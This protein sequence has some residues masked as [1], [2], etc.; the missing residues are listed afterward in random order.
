[1]PR[2]A[3][4][5]T[6]AAVQAELDRRTTAYLAARELVVPYYRIGYTLAFPLPLDHRPESLPPSPLG[7]RPYPWLIWLGWHLEDRWRTF[8]TGRAGE[9][10]LARELVAL[11]EWTSYDA[12][13]GGAGLV[14][15]ALAGV[16]GAVLARADGHEPATVAAA[17]TVGRRLLEESFRPWYLD[18]WR[19]VVP[20]AARLEALHNIR[21]IAL[22]RAAQLASV[23]DSDATGELEERAGQVY[24]AWL[25]RR[26]AG[27]PMTEGPAYDGFLLDTLTEWIAARPDRDE[28]LKR[29]ED[30]L[31][32]LP[33]EWA[34]LS[35]PGRPDLLAPVGDTEGEMPYWLA[36]AIRLCH[37]YGD[38]QA[39]A[40][41]RRTSLS[42]VPAGALA[43]AARL[44]ADPSAPGREP[45][46][47]GV[48][49]GASA[50]TM[51]A[52]WEP[53]DPLVVVG[54]SRSPLGHLHHDG[55]HVLIGWHGRAWITDPGYQQYRPGPE[56][57]FTVGPEAHN[58][59]VIGGVSQ[60]ERDAVPSIL[61]EDAVGLDLSGCYPDLPGAEVRREVRLA[62]GRVVVR[63]EVRGLPAGT[64]VAT[65]W[66]AGAGL[67][68]S[69]DSGAARLSDGRRA[70][71]IVTAPGGL[72][73]DL[74][75]RPEGTRGPLRLTH[76]GT[77]AVRRWAFVFDEAG[78]RVPP[79]ERRHTALEEVTR[80]S[81]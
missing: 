68:W 64:T 34:S 73:P 7:A 71:W 50:L 53:A 57:E 11:G 37:W 16:V 79:P 26:R 54:A 74:L 8:A 69:F 6:P 12:D 39:G 27:R 81:T 2:S 60:S 1:M 45:A 4:G 42:R 46:G 76:T 29:G 52:G 35:L 56:R 41:L 5:W 9:A 55:G 28:L 75:S 51:R 23:L 20:L 38:E 77:D 47:L 14:T 3:A 58:A 19:D 32:G 13:Y 62:A 31:A 66:L 43:D 44:C 33:A 59:P 67:A 49:V 72:G 15:G 70:V 48:R 80:W 63:D 40:R 36:A 30:V 78:G 18:A 17:G 25:V 24:D 21:C 22:F 65:H 10:A 61:G